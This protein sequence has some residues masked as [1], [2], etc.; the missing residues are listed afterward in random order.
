MEAKSHYP[1]PQVF[2]HYKDRDTRSSD[3]NPYKNDVFGLGMT[4]L[5]AA[6]LKHVDT[7]YDF[8]T[9]KVRQEV[10]DDSL[11]HLKG[12]YS[13]GF[14]EALRVLLSQEEAKRPT[15]VELDDEIKAYRSD[16]R[17]K[18]VTSFVNI[19]LIFPIEPRKDFGGPKKTW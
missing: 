12:R 16:I 14:V 8:K 2:K 4:I 10:I 13:E 17:A 3:F 9:K 11:R 6:Q 19:S 15:F 1:S 5:A 18:A 7:A